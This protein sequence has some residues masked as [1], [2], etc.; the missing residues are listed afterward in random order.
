MSGFSFGRSNTSGDD[1]PLKQSAKYKPACKSKHVSKTSQFGELYT[2]DDNDDEIR[3]LEKL[4]TSK[5]AA[6]YGGENDENEEGSKKLQ[7]ISKVLNQNANA[8]DVKPSDY[9]SLK[10]RKESKNLKPVR[11]FEDT[12]YVE[13]EESLSDAELKPKKKHCKDLTD[14]L[15]SARN[16]MAMTTRRRALQTGKE[17]SS[18]SSSTSAVDFP[19][20]LPPPPK[21]EY[22]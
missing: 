5:F 6:S 10:V 18:L 11:A 12:D 1:I 9:N 2:E 21:S 22:Q 14:I 16:E 8:Y 17:V 13:E 7:R 15:G 20:G 3:Y 19:H 4:K